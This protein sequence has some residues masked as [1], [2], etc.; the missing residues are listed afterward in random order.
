[1]LGLRWSGQYERI[2]RDEVLR[3]VARLIRVTRINPKGGRPDT[4]ALPL[5]Y[6]NG[7]LFSV[8]V[9]RVNEDVYERIKQYK[10]ECYQVLYRHFQS[11]ALAR[12]ESGSPLAQIRELGLAIARQAEQQMLLE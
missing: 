1:A 11:E 6:L 8:Q 12:R 7:W 5:E 4:L 10:R 9:K 2:Q 3:D